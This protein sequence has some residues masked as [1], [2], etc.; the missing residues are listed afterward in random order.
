MKYYRRNKANRLVV[1]F[2]RF[3]Q[4]G[5]L[6]KILVL[7]FLPQKTF[8][9]LQSNE[10]VTKNDSSGAHYALPRRYQTG[11][12]DWRNYTNSGLKTKCHEAQIVWRP[13]R[14]K[15]VEKDESCMSSSENSKI[16]NP[17]MEKN[18]IPDQK[19]SQETSQWGTK[20]RKCIYFGS[21]WPINQKTS[22]EEMPANTHG[23]RTKLHSEFVDLFGL[24]KK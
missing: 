19:S 15:K 18:Q 13:G 22:N 3:L 23:N 14:K 9:W 17:K 8:T 6:N 1:P 16:Q 7:R 2:Y 4:H 11:R 20:K 5:A 21:N 12:K 10:K 24:P